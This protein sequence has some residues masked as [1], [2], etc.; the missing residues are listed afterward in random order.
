MFSAL[1]ERALWLAIGGTLTPEAAAESVVSM[2]LDGARA[3]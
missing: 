2:F 3:R 1:V